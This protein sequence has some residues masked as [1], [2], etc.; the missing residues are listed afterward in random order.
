[1]WP[2]ATDSPTPDDQHA[3]LLFELAPRRVVEVVVGLD[4]PA[5]A[6]PSCPRNGWPRRCTSSTESR[7]DRTVS[8]TTSTV[9]ATGGY[10]AGS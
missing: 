3:G 4:E 8:S 7:P 1:M 9:T 2:S 5:R 10:R 6:A